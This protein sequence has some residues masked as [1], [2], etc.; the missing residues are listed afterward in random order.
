[1]FGTYRT[2]LALLVVFL[3][4]GGIPVVG[5]YA[6]F[7][8]YALSGYLMTLIMHKNYGYSVEGIF[9]YALNR[10]LRIFPMYWLSAFMTVLLVLYVGKEFSIEFHQAM[11]LPETAGEIIK[12]ILIIFPDGNGPRL[13]P[14]AWALTVELFYYICIGLGLSRNKLLVIIWFILSV[15]YHIV[16]SSM[17]L[18]WGYRY[19][20]ISAASLPFSTGALIYFYKDELCRMVKYQYLPHF[21]VLLLLLN[22]VVGFKLNTLRDMSFYINYVINTFIIISLANKKSLAWIP[23]RFDRWMGDYSFPIYLIHYQV[24][25]I[26]VI[27]FGLFDMN[28]GMPNIILMFISIPV[29]LIVSWIMIIAIE[30]PIE[31]IRFKVKSGLMDQNKR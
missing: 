20:M 27:I 10:F 5:A 3:H 31:F 19:S 26:V 17:G 2:F 25:L 11:Y 13:T 23:K 15:I 29:I 14:P 24:G 4:L 8:F 7:G 22:W 1:M 12:N 9:K 18:D 30:R 21:L 28:M 16:I 6:V